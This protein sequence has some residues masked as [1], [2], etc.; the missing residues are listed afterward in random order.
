MITKSSKSFWSL[1]LSL[2]L[3][4]L[5]PRDSGDFLVKAA[6]PKPASEATPWEDLRA[7][8]SSP[9]ILTS[10]TANEW[11]EQCVQAFRD[12]ASFPG[13]DGRSPVVTNYLLWNQSS[14]L[15]LDHVSC[16]FENCQ[17]PPADD[18]WPN[19]PLSTSSPF[20]IASSSMDL[21][22]D[23]LTSDSLWLPAMVLEPTSASDIVQA[24]E[25]CQKNDVGIT[26]K[27]AGHS[28][29][30]ASS[31]KDTL[32]IKM[33]PSYPK[34]A[35]GGS[36]IECANLEII[37]DE[38]DG[39]VPSANE[40]ACKV[41]E[42]RGKNAVMR[43]GGGELFDEAYRAVSFDWNSAND[44]RYHLVGGG[45]GTVSAAGG[46][47]ASGG[48]SG[49][50]GMRMYGI[51]I[52]QVVALEMVLPNGQHVRFGPTEWTDSTIEGG[53]PTTTAVTGYCN[54][55]TKADERLWEWTACDETIDF[56]ELWFAARGGGGGSYGIVTS[57]HYQLHD[58]PGELNLVAPNLESYP[59][60]TQDITAEAASA[61]TSKYIEFILRYLYSPETLNVTKADS[62]GCNSAQ[63]FNL[64]PFVDGNLFCYGSSGDTLVSK[65]QEYISDPV[66]VGELR[67][68]GVADDVIGALPGLLIND[69]QTDSYADIV[70][71]AGSYNPYIPEGRLAD[72]P[73]AGVVPVLGG[74]PSLVDSQH[75]H[76]PLA[77][78]TAD[79][80]GMAQLL[81]A[82]ILGSGAGGTIYAMGGFIPA[83]DDG[84]NSLSPTRRN[85]AFLLAVR[86]ENYRNQY[87]KL[88]YGGMDM[89]GDFPGSSCHNH[90]LVYEMGPLKDDWTKTCPQ[91][92]TQ[93]EREEKCISQN[94]A[95]WG[96][97]NLARLSA[98]K[99]SIDPNGVFICTSGIGYSNPASQKPTSNASQMTTIA[100]TKV[101][102]LVLSSMLLM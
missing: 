60:S 4:L 88:F 101:V 18:T 33:N 42:S 25:F 9:D 22:A 86:D 39:Y 11:N 56:N 40:M 43:V 76:F 8:L 41:A 93:P 100:L 46:W 13:V 63:T 26:V 70:L 34:Y 102:F 98:F 6:L 38:D 28:Y 44:N 74:F 73:A 32:L 52:D 16:A 50:T 97:F 20:V 94:E 87:Y 89:S 68:T 99:T 27:V 10:S 81:A 37:P 58:Y 84:L 54:A 82:D 35:I 15:C 51:G 1:A 2:V 71:V 75:T 57:L 92:W 5:P 49:T 72:S 3:L 79:P 24:V 80:A 90:A 23:D 55:K 45:A 47:M 61:F 7:V 91:S 12:A 14:G 48:L 83:A 30:G 95:S 69:S 53:Y 67:S 36:L 21:T 78:I 17:W 77:A 19:F 31:A 29:F 59:E 96:T 66:V 65:W 64:S 85:A 62:R